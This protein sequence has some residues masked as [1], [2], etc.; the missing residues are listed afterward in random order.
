H[1]RTGVELMVET[2]QA[3]IDSSGGVPLVTI[4]SAA[5]TVAVHLGAYDLTAALGVSAGD[6]R[7]D[8][9]LCDVARATMKLAFA[10]TEIEVVDGATTILPVGGDRNA[11][12]NA[13]KMH[14]SNV[15]RAL[16]FGITR[17]WDLH[18]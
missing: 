11:V 8:H 7:L 9:P 6:Q 1:G 2:P 10:G 16:D 3:L 13:W 4:A 18:P 12:Q 14:A 15:R 17:G 5:R